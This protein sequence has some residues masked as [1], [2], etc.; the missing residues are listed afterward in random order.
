[1]EKPALRT[2]QTGFLGRGCGDQSDEEHGGDECGLVFE[3]IVG[4]GEANDGGAFGGVIVAEIA[5]AQAGIFD[6]AGLAVPE[7]S[8]GAVDQRGV[9]FELE[10][11]IGAGEGLEIGLGGQW[12]GQ[13]AKTDCDQ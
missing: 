8:L 1:M 9:V 12:D 6:P 13:G 3:F 11:A 2:L 4:V 5:L 7:C 10:G